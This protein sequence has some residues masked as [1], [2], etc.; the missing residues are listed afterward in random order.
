M[1]AILKGLAIIA[2]LFIMVGCGTVATVQQTK[3]QASSNAFE[4]KKI[5]IKDSYRQIYWKDGGA[6]MIGSKSEC[7]VHNRNPQSCNQ[8][9]LTIAK[10]NSPVLQC[11]S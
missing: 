9:F 3:I 2:T 7:F 1:K 4:N 8:E 5:H 10:Q 6:H 11:K